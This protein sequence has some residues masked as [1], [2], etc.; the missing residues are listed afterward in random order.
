[1]MTKEELTGVHQLLQRITLQPAEIPA[2]QQ[3]MQVIQREFEIASNPLV[4]KFAVEDTDGN[5]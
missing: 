1:M 2:Y 5:S 3:I 4:P